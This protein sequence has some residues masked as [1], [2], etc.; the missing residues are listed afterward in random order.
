MLSHT[1]LIVDDEEEALKLLDIELSSEGYQV[2]KAHNGREAVKKA[3]DFRPSLILLDIL[4][5]DLDGGQVIKLL[6]ADPVT[7]HIPIIFLTA[8]LTREEE[9]SKQI[10][11]T[12]E[13]VSYPAI[14]KP[15][16]VHELLGEVDRLI[17]H[18]ETRDHSV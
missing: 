11:V 3:H 6:K 17:H 16:N 10:G 4:M 2:V 18:A 15:F 13:H 5:P 12:V 9:R 14:A 8:V 7:E 1:V